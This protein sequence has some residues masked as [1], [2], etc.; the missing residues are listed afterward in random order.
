MAWL[1]V[2]QLFHPHMNVVFSRHGNCSATDVL[3]IPPVWHVKFTYQLQSCSC[4][5]HQRVRQW[6]RNLWS[7]KNV[8]LQKFIVCSFALSAFVINHTSK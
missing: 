8:E 7:G 5:L 4:L 3:S 1:L 2:N 6:E